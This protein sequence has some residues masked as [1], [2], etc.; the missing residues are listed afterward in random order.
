M[1]EIKELKE[2]I[3]A[4]DIQIND[5]K[6]IEGELKSK[7]KTITVLNRENEILKQ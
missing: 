2:I 5:L 7:E 6:I 1:N 3:K 4:K